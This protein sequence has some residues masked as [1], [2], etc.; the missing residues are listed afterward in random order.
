[1]GGVVEEG[2]AT[3]LQDVPGIVGAKTGT[4]QFGDGSKAHVW[5]LA[6]THDMAAVV[7]IEEGELGS[8]TAG[9]VMHKFLTG[10]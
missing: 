3:V 7:F 4:A 9:P 6:I 10:S 2:S 5:M 1:M 8:T